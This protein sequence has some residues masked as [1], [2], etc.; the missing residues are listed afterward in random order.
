MEIIM[1]VLI[2]VYLSGWF[3]ADSVRSGEAPFILGTKVTKAD[4]LIF[5]WCSVAFW[6]LAFGFTTYTF[7]AL[8]IHALSGE[9]PF[10]TR[11]LLPVN[12]KQWAFA[13]MDLFFVLV[14][15]YMAW[16]KVRL[17]RLLREIEAEERSGA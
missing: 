16:R 15:A 8:S 2:W 17:N 6:F 7:A 4:D 10:K 9:P 14:F 13:A 11:G 3:F 5:Y 12:T 1:F